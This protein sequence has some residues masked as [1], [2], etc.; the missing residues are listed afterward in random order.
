MVHAWV[1]GPEE[2]PVV[3]F[4]QGATMDHRMFDAQLKPLVQAGYRVV[5]W[6]VRGHG[7]SRPI[8]RL[9]LRISDMTDDLLAILDELGVS[10]RVCV[11]GQSMGGYVAQDLVRRSPDRVAALIVIGST[12]TT[13]PISRGERWGLWTSPLWLA[14]WPWGHLKRTVV[15]STALRPEVRAYV[16][17]VLEG[18]SRR[19]FVEVWRAVARTAVRPEPGYR[20]EAP[21][22]LVHGAEDRTGNIARTAP[23]WAER[24]PLCRYEV[25]PDA[26]HN[27][28]QDDPEAFNRIMLEF[29]GEHYPAATP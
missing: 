10:G 4:T 27:A 12:C 25:V 16:A 28:N 29:L 1:C 26:A 14:A 19:E 9:P 6:D 13:L 17:E 15:T 18:M 23:A 2:G 3:A 20:I 8:G 5:T 24:D 22:L 7:R 11:G 21:L